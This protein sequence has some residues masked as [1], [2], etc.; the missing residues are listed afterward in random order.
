MSSSLLFSF[1]FTFLCLDWFLKFFKCF[2]NFF[3]W[4]SLALSCNYLSLFTLFN[5][6][7]SYHM[8]AYHVILPVVALAVSLS[9]QPINL[10][11]T[12]NIMTIV[13]TGILSWI[14]PFIDI[15]LCR[16]SIC[17]KRTKIVN[18]SIFNKSIVQKDLLSILSYFTSWLRLC[19]KGVF[20][21]C[22]H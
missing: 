21:M 9:I 6:I 3:R 13:F 2:W 22:F 5:V 7:N 8:L 17:F 19:R 14:I 10:N 12:K 20:W 18:V 4:S 15:L 11:N 1:L 16:G